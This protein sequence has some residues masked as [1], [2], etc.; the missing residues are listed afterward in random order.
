MAQNIC[1]VSFIQVIARQACLIHLQL[2]LFLNIWETI[3]DMDAQIK[4]VTSSSPNANKKHTWNFT[5][6]IAFVLVHNKWIK[7]NP[8]YFLNAYSRSYC[9][10]FIV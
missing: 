9:E 7:I 6:T 8:I 10:R 2:D 4:V 3:S 5:F 1:D